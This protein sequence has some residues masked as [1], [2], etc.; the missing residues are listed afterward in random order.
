M[1][2]FSIKDVDKAIKTLEE[3]K[4][5]L[6]ETE[7]GKEEKLKPFPVEAI[8][9]SRFEIVLFP[10]KAYNKIVF[11]LRKLYKL[12][13]PDEPPF[14]P[15]FT[16]SRLIV[17]YSQERIASFLVISDTREMQKYEPRK[18]FERKGG[19]SDENGLFITSVCG[20][21]ERYY[22]LLKKLFAQLISF[23]STKHYTYL[24]LHVS[25][26]RPWLVPKYK[27]QGFEKSG[28]FTDKNDTF[29]ILLNKI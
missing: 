9:Y 3:E 29:L 27:S 10:S 14:E 23:A 8:E 18:D 13:E 5:I 2:P 20:D 12:C 15:S 21:T 4:K 16:P 17:G 19:L 22:G 11:E 6:K 7:E 26:T 25:S 28:E 1:L 24:L